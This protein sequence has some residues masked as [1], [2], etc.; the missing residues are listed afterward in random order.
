MQIGV[1]HGDTGWRHDIAGGDVARALL[2]QVHRHRLVLLGADHEL[3]EVE[4]DVGDVFLDARNGGELVQ[5]PVDADAGDRG[6]GDR[7]EQGST[8]RIAQGVAESRLQRLDD[9]P[10]TGEIDRFLTE[11]R[12][13]SDQH[14]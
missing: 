14:G 9:E 3:L 4:D 6:T 5:H 8:Q 13:L 1:V 12:P 11:V 10:R 7:R 2:A